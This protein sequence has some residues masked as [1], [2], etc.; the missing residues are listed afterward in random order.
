M[1]YNKVKNDEKVKALVDFLEY[2]FLIQSSELEERDQNYKKE[3]G[4]T[5]KM[6]VDQIRKL[7]YKQEGKEE[8]IK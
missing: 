1:N 8:G 7:H 5:L 3:K 2:L 4:G 6:T